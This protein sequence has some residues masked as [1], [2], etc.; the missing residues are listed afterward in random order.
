MPRSSPSH[1]RHGQAGGLAAATPARCAIAGIVALVLVLVLASLPRQRPAAAAEQGRAPSPV[2]AQHFSGFTGGLIAATGQVPVS[3]A[4]TPADDGTP[5]AGGQLPSPG[6][7]ASALAADGIPETALIA[8]QNAAQRE[9]LL[10]PACQLTW[11]LLAAIGRVESDHGRFGGAVLYT[12]GRSYPKIIGIPLDGNGTALIRDTD[13]G[14]L[15]GDTVYD[16]AVGPMQFIPSTWARWGVDADGDGVADPFDIFDAA[17]AAAAYLCSSGADLATLSGQYR[18][19]FSYNHLDQYVRTVLALAATYAAG[20]PARDVLVTPDGRAPSSS[21]PA[22]SR[23]APHPA[24]PSSIAPVPTPGTSPGTV[25]TSPK[26]SAPTG[27]T[28]STSPSSSDCPSTTES[29]TPSV[30][31]SASATA[32]S[33]PTATPSD[34]GCPTPSPSTTPSDSTSA[35]PTETPADTPTASITPE[36]PAP[37][38]GSPS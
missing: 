8:Y 34:S 36:A 16:R 14:R 33:T 38:A 22:T 13:H 5:P 35:S 37:Q 2:A 25:T 9:R 10:D 29:A 26:T 17:A 6:L 27:E 7:A 4:S 15:D 19:V 28:P 12:D 32:T 23:A 21:A 3:Q 11:P 30:T 20:V 1:P 31:P 18:A 24:A